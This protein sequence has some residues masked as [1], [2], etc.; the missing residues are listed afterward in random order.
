MNKKL[1]VVLV[2]RVANLAFLKPDFEILA[3]LAH[4]AFYEK[5]KSKKSSTFWRVVCWKSL[6]LTKHS[7]SC[8]FITNLF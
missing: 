8:I 4:L 2:D 3:F 6:A 7:L 1:K 5:E